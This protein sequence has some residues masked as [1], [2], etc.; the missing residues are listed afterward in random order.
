MESNNRKRLV[1]MLAAGLVGVLVG[2]L[3]TGFVARASEQEKPAAVDPNNT[4]D[5][6]GM[7][8]TLHLEKQGEDGLRLRGCH[9]QELGSSEKEFP[10]GKG[11]PEGLVWKA[12]KVKIEWNGK[13][14]GSGCVE[15]GGVPYCW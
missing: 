15:V 1:G 14:G 12:E 8:V 7:T 6:S 2:A 11:R 10:C 9:A 4:H 3:V 13:Q 5:N